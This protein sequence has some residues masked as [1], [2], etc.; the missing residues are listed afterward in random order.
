MKSKEI[1]VIKVTNRQLYDQH[2]IIINGQ[3]FPIDED[4][5]KERDILRYLSHQ[6]DCPSSIV[7]YK[8]YFKRYMV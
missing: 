1:V 2:A 8:G 7:K 5:K 6:Q 4:I 3:L